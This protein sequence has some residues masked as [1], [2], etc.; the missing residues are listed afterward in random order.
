[1]GFGEIAGFQ[2]FAQNLRGIHCRAL[3][4]GRPKPGKREPGLV[5]QKNQIRLDRQA[6]FHETFDIVDDAVEGAVGQ[7]EHADAIKLS[8]CSQFQQSMFDFAQRDR[9]VHGVFVE[10]IGIQVDDLSAGQDHAVMVRL[11]TVAVDEHDVTGAHQGL[12]DNLV[13]GRG[14]VGG[15]KRLLRSKRP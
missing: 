7:K 12:H 6:F 1:M 11:V 15:K 9:P 10:R 4:V 8:G 13:A 2:T 14:A 3:A 5:P